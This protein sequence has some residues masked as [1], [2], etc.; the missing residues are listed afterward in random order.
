MK[1]FAIATVA[2]VS[3]IAMSSTA[4]AASCYDLWYARNQ[5]YADNGFCFSTSLAIRTFGN[6]GCYTKHPHFSKREQR[7]IDAIAAEEA[8]RG[9]H[10]NN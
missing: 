5:I 6:D 8:D 3:I 9:C 1:L 10:V 2:T 7:K 4:M